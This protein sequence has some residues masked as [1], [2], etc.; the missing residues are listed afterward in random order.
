MI[1]EAHSPNPPSDLGPTN[2]PAT[3]APTLIFMIGLIGLLWAA[4]NP[5]LAVAIVMAV[6]LATIVCRRVLAYL[7]RL[8]H[9]H[10]TKLDVPGL[11]IVELRVTPR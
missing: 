2:S 4:S 3:A 8:M 7:A 10:I 6:G 5:I 11:G 9:G 1:P